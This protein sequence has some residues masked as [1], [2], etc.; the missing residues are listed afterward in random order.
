M[1][2]VQPGALALGP[3]VTNKQNS[4]M[5]IWILPDVSTWLAYHT[6]GS[7]PADGMDVNLLFL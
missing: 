1:A 2:A 3:D 5:N 6:L 7:N 4:K